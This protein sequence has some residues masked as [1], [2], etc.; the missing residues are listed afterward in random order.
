MATSRPSE[1][2]Y[3]LQADPHEIKNL[4]EDSA[5]RDTLIEMRG[6]LEQWIQESG[7]HGRNPEPPELIKKEI[8]VMMEWKT[9]ELEELYRKEGMF[10]LFK[11]DFE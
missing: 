2:L 4:A 3:D 6:Q 8:K 9:G 7:D 11:P 10:H 1:E 5:Y